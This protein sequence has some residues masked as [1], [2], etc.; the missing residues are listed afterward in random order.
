MTS[1]DLFFCANAKFTMVF[2]ALTQN[3]WYLT[4]QRVSRTLSLRIS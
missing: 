3:L 4:K 1:T 2:F